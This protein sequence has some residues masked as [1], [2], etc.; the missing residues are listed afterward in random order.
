MCFQIDSW[1]AGILKP[2]EISKSVTWWLDRHQKSSLMDLNQQMKLCIPSCFSS[3]QWN[4][5]ECLIEFKELYCLNAYWFLKS[6]LKPSKY[7]TK[8]KTSRWTHQNFP[9]PSYHFHSI[10]FFAHPRSRYICSVS[11]RFSAFLRRSEKNKF[12]LIESKHDDSNGER[13]IRSKRDWNESFFESEIHVGSFF[14]RM[15]LKKKKRKK[16]KRSCSCLAVSHPKKTFSC[17]F[18]AALEGKNHHNLRSLLLRSTC[19]NIKKTQLVLWWH[20]NAAF[21]GV[22]WKR[23][24][25]V[26]WL[27][28]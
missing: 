18:G 14:L 13:L 9:N 4:V 21:F 22:V 12:G 1:K 20:E 10:V 24:R 7:P 28:F 19:V 15:E 3:I 2:F 16:K 6:S 8:S 26:C 27:C 5:C 23:P 17:G 25:K 11:E